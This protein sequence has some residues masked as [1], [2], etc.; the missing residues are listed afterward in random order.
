LQMANL[1]FQNTESA[2][3]DLKFRVLVRTRYS[4]FAPRSLSTAESGLNMQ[5]SENGAGAM[6]AP[7]LA[8]WDK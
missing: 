5:R 2:I 8:D 3:C 7:G 6:I 1:K 4:R